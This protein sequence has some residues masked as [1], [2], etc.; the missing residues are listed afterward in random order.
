MEINATTFLC[1]RVK[2]Y[3]FSRQNCGKFES[4]RDSL[5]DP[6]GLPCPHLLVLQR[7]KNAFCLAPANNNLVGL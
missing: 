5:S 6:R 3:D 1:L 4:Q 7:S 2:Y